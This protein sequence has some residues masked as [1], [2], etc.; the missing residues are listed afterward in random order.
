MY[1]ALLQHIEGNDRRIFWILVATLAVVL[2]AYV[3][4]L[5]SSV[6]SVITRKEAESESKQLIA[7]ISILESEYVKLDKAVS[8]E[9]AHANGFI[10]IAVPRYISREQ[11]GS[12]FTL[13]NE[14]ESP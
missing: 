1:R 12:T 3:Y 8:L 5:G 11:T 6:Y 2:F 9:L 13:R 7:K 4:F 10:D 14:T